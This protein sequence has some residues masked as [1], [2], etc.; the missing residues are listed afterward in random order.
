[1]ERRAILQYGVH[2]LERLA[3]RPGLE[4]GAVARGVHVREVEHRADPVDSTR[5]VHDVVDRAEIANA[6]HDLDPERHGAAL[7]F[8]PRAQRAELFH[9]RVD[10]VV[11]TATEEEPGMEDDELGAARRCDARAAVE[12]ADCRRELATARLEMAHEPEQRRMHRERDVVLS[13]ELAELLGER[14]VHPE[15]ALEVDLAGRVPA[16]EKNLDRLLRR[17]AGRHAGGADTKARS[18]PSILD[19]EM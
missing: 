9:D 4:K 6:T 18:H 2:L 12:G 15:P 1:M 16:G 3:E 5:D 13:G 19:I 14:V 8:E 10:G 11:A 7:R 17:L